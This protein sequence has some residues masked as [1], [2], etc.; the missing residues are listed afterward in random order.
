M[1]CSEFVVEDI[2][3]LPRGNEEV[4]IKTPEIAVYVFLADDPLN[5]VDRGGMAFGDES[6]VLLPVHLFKSDEAVVHGIGEMSRGPGRLSIANIAGFDDDNVDPFKRKAICRR[7]AGDSRTN[8]T[9][10]RC[11]IRSQRA[12]LRKR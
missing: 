9:N 11:D 7:H 4:S 6:G 10:I 5:T 8:H 2:C 3:R 1:S 12:D